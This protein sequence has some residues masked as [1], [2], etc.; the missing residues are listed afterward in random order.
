MTIQ[1]VCQVLDGVA[2][3]ALKDRNGYVPLYRIRQAL[4][5]YIAELEYKSWG[6]YAAN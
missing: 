3:E 1:E 6:N 2:T 4:E 5:S